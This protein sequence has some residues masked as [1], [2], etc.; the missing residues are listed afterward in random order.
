MRRFC[1]HQGLA[2]SFSKKQKTAWSTNL[3][4]LDVPHLS[5]NLLHSAS[6]ITCSYKPLV[7][8]LIKSPGVQFKNFSSSLVGNGKKNGKSSELWKAGD[9]F[10]VQKLCVFWYCHFQSNPD[11][12]CTPL[13]LI[14]GRICVTQISEKQLWK[15]ANT[16]SGALKNLSFHWQI[17]RFYYQ[18]LE[19]P[20]ARD[21]TRTGS[22][23][24]GIC[25]RAGIWP[26][27]IKICVIRQSNLSL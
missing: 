15:M 3:L 18:S 17:I 23:S 2:S 25:G 22:F 21:T 8:F 12:Q 1:S 6:L 26:W 14:L 24:S 27:N 20:R 11:F 7:S 16:A 19:K 10:Q 13:V 9:K 5:V 4:A